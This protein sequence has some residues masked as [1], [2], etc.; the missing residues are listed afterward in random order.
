MCTCK[1]YPAHPFRGLSDVPAHRSIRNRNGPG[2]WAESEDDEL[3]AAMR[4]ESELRV[5]K[6]LKL[7]SFYAQLYLQS[8]DKHLV[9]VRPR[10]CSTERKQN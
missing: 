4:Q 2:V 6:C 3:L 8:Q 9:H 7:S 10:A 1:C 5:R